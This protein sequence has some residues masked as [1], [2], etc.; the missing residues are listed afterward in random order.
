M[1]TFFASKMA[2]LLGDRLFEISGQGPPPQKDFFQLVI[3]KNEVILTS[4]RISLRLE[5]RGLPPNQQ[6]TS[7]QDFQNDKTLQYEVGAV[8]GQRILDY[9]AALCQGKFDYLERLPDDIMLRI[10]YCLELK[11]T[12][13]L[14]QTSRRFKTVRTTLFSSEKFWEQTVRN[15]AGFNRDIEDIANAMGWKSTFLTFFHNSDDKKQQ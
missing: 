15:C 14:A 3:T 9:T 8:F 5:C 6:K 1:A 11:D 10:M 4:W 12:A 7:H 2:S 13:L